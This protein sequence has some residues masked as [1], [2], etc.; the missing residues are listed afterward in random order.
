MR[1][2]SNVA[3]IVATLF[4]VASPTS[5]AITKGVEAVKVG[6]RLGVKCYSHLLLHKLQR[7]HRRTLTDFER[8]REE[9]WEMNKKP[10][11]QRV[12]VSR[13]T[14]LIISAIYLFDQRHQDR[15]GNPIPQIHRPLHQIVVG[16]IVPKRRGVQYQ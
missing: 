15:L 5:P 6:T 16:D 12:P 1:S 7:H 11:Y 4:K 2:K 10:T 9:K 13:P 8:E 3:S 14:K